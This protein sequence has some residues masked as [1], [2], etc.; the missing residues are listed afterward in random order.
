[1]IK[2]NLN[3]SHVFK[4]VMIGV[5]SLSIVSSAVFLIPHKMSCDSESMASVTNL[6]IYNSDMDVDIASLGIQDPLEQYEYKSSNKTAYI[7]SNAVVIR[8]EPSDESEVIFS[9]DY[10]SKVYIMG[11]DINQSD[12]WTKVYL[13]NVS[14]FVRTEYIS[15]DMLFVPETRYIYISGQT[16][17]RS[18]PDAEKDNVVQM[19]EQNN[20]F[21]QTG[22]NDDWIQIEAND[23]Y[24][25]LS[26]GFSSDNMIF[27][28]EEKSI[29]LNKNCYLKTRP[30]TG[31]KY[32]SDICL[33][34]DS[35]IDQVEY[36]ESWVKILYDGK[37]YYVEKNYTTPYLTT[38]TQN[39]YTITFDDTV[40]SG[41]IAVV[42]ERAYSFLGQSYVW[43]AASPTA[44]DCS[45]LTMQC[46]AAVGVS[47]PHQS[48][49]QSYYGRDVMNEALKPGDLL[50]FSSR[51]SSHIS[52]VGIYVG[53]GMMIHASNSRDG[54][55]ASD[56][57]R[58]CENGGTMRAA[59]RIIED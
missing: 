12:G 30:F 44:M 43:G 9:T 39:S 53:D 31:E 4:K 21:K 38:Y 17:L 26:S 42:L 28:E 27:I 10:A 22:Y 46:Y 45:G 23:T 5:F 8:K 48:A 14:G 56:L 6:N 34:K 58:Y 35:K 49:E 7:N 32:N 24:Y 1:M 40:Y 18:E 55:I 57:A 36:N 52:H 11:E 51:W 33:E 15:Y 50:M 29:Y 47:L 16:E 20:R 3:S 25:Y 41:D 37:Y 59:R 13:N 54:V 19:L 2:F